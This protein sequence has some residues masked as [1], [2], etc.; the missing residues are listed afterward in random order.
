MKKVYSSRVSGC[1]CLSW[2]DQPGTNACNRGASSEM[3][4]VSASFPVL[5]LLPRHNTKLATVDYFQAI[6]PTSCRGSFTP[7]QWGPDC[8]KNT[9]TMSVSSVSTRPDQRFHSRWQPDGI[10]SIQWT[11]ISGLARLNLFPMQYTPNSICWIT[12]VIIE[13]HWSVQKRGKVCGYSQTHASESAI[14]VAF[15]LLEGCRI[16]RAISINPCGAC[17]PSYTW[18]RQDQ[19]ES[20]M[21]CCRKD[22][23]RPGTERVLLRSS[24]VCLLVWFG[25]IVIIRP[26]NW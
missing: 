21:N 5:Y 14:T 23:Q 2:G 1:C 13:M 24:H 4:F 22:Q 25:C 6:S 20:A 17:R 15:S 10:V 11:D 16:Y 9:Y 26:G 8:A 19:G 18:C 12:W 7:P 3:M